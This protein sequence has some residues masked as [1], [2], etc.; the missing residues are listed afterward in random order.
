MFV[1]AQDT[2][3]TVLVWIYGGLKQLGVLQYSFSKL[4][5]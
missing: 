4:F 1:Q 5:K 2:C 3:K